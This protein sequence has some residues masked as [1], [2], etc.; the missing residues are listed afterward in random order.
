MT[1]E[2]SERLPL[3]T[4]DLV[5]PD[6]TVH[7]G[8]DTLE[9]VFIDLGGGAGVSL[10][11]GNLVL[12][13]DAFGRLDLPTTAQMALTYNHQEPEGAPDLAPGW[14]YDLARAWIP[15]AWGERVLLDADGFRDSFWAGKPPTADE[16]DRVT[17]DVVAAWKRDTTRADRRAL[18]GVSALEEL[19]V[20][21][22]A[23]LGAM[24]LRYLGAPELDLADAP[25][26][27]SLARGGRVFDSDGDEVVLNLPDGGR[28]VFGE[29][30]FL[31]R[32]EPAAGPDWALLRDNGSLRSVSRDG[33][34]AWTFD[35]DSRYRLSRVADSTGAAAIYEYSGSLLQSVDGPVGDWGF[36]YDGRSRLVEARTPAG[37]VS[38][39]YDDATGR[40]RAASGP[41]GAFE[42]SASL[43]DDGLRV[44]V[45]GLPGGGWTVEWDAE[46][47]Q[48][49]LTQRGDP[50][51]TAQFADLAAYPTRIELPTGSLELGWDPSGRL[52]R[53]SQRG[54]EVEWER[55]PD[56]KLLALIDTGGAR[57]PT[58]DSE[59]G[60]KGWTDPSGRSTTLERS[61]NGHVRD[62]TRSGGA[63]LNLRR[64]PGGGLS[65]ISI[66]EGTELAVPPPENAVGEVRYERASAGVRRDPE[67]RLVG[68]EA[69]GGRIVSFVLGA[70]GAVEQIRGDRTSVNL[71]YAG[72]LLASWNGPEGS[73]TVRRDGDGLVLGLL[74]GGSPRWELRR[75]A[76]GG[77]DG[78]LLDGVE[79]AV[80][81]DDD[82]LQSWQRP[83]GGR[84]TVRRR[85]DGVVESL[86]TAATGELGLEIDRA[87]WVI[88]VRRGTGRWGVTRDRSGRLQRIAEPG[89]AVDF[90]LDDGG[91]PQSILTTSGHGW[92]LR[93]DTL[94]RLTGFETTDA[95]FVL[96]HGR[97]GSPERFVRPD[98]A[99]ARLDYDV[100][101]RWTG[102][103]L[104]DGAVSVS[105]GVLGPTAFGEL[106]WRLDSS[107]ALIGWGR[108][109]DGQLR[110]FADRD[111]DGRVRGVRSDV[112]ERG[113]RRSPEGR[114]VLVGELELDWSPEGLEG[115]T[116]GEREWRLERD[117][118]GRVRR[119]EG[120][121][122]VFVVERERNGDARL[123]RLSRGAAEGTV[124][125]ARDPAGRLRS[126]A[127]DGALG[128]GSWTL[129]R[130]PMGRL[131]SAMDAGG[132]QSAITWRDVVRD[133]RGVLAEALAVQTDDEPLRR[134]ASGAWDIDV[135]EAGLTPVPF[136]S[137]PLPGGRHSK[138]WF[139]PRD[140]AAG[141]PPA[142]L[143]GVRPPFAQPVEPPLHL[144]GDSARALRWWRGRGPRSED[145]ALMPEAVPESGRAW[146]HGR[147]GAIAR[148][149]G[150]PEDVGR[151]GA[152]A[153]MPPVPGA[154]ALVPGAPGVRRVSATEALVLSGDLPP[155]A[156]LWTDLPDLPPEAWRLD[157]PGAA[158]LAALRGR[159]AHPAMPPMRY[160]DGLAVVQPGAQG[161]MTRRGRDQERARSWDVR[162]VVDGLPPGTVD[163]LPGSPG[164][165][166]GTPGS[167]G[168]DGRATV[169]DALSDDPF[170]GREA[171][172][173]QARA[174]SILLALRALVNGTRTGFGGTLP[175][176]AAAESWLIELPSGTRVVLDGRGR[177]LSVD[178]GGRLL[179]SHAGA[180]SALA[181]QELLAP[182][183]DRWAL[184]EADDD[185]PWNPQYLPGRGVAVESR[186]GLVPAMPEFPLDAQGRPALP[187]LPR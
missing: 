187:G 2:R 110:W 14:T 26:Y 90:T 174:D 16:L 62:V 123:L 24:R 179:R 15:G 34:A 155:E 144:D 140:V 108:P 51:E 143:E 136:A 156:L 145:L 161:V 153:L 149:A 128:S 9:D 63:D 94:G 126:L 35:T 32:I 44:G 175:D 185:S 142:A 102:M 100:R 23:T 184:S 10:L 30:G 147:T 160:G 92:R 11:S 158:V 57:G 154:T 37:V 7:L 106:R 91:R 121:G 4:R 115:L 181:G 96:E 17:R 68:F 83:D 25:V 5:D 56:G 93:R 111:T 67:G 95:S 22:P 171:A 105:W 58:E 80:D 113:I 59:G 8:W 107:G 133:E 97:G 45:E 77:L 54:R 42:L 43:A 18:G 122:A 164:W 116:R 79:L 88:G 138:A 19:L 38:V 157:L 64:R 118:A 177:L 12:R 33:R 60:L 152:G 73:R 129:T 41:A 124:E 165:V 85:S 84:V 87:G 169:W 178:A 65:L 168:A 159:L 170:G 66:L 127:F 98:G 150:V 119:L 89:G 82:G 70:H 20:S 76:D 139:L 186:W 182:T 172:H 52:T 48:R 46:R 53:S 61:D 104:P 40:V 69:P 3:A 148:A 162:P 176:P 6:P 49:T 109:L 21:D 167:T 134:E 28:E 130:D 39:S 114:P 135:G 101:G 74:E 13:V 29:N 166:A 163:V 103:G 125:L 71:S 72:G 1:S 78:L 55:D 50:V 120:P 132:L 36:R 27:S 183:L 112:S 117:S 151:A 99:D 141:I 47:R 31:R 173:G 137:R 86:E 131:L 81:L 146:A 75:G 180:M